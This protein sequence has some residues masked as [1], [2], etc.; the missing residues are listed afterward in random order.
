MLVL[1]REAKEMVRWGCI[2]RGIR[3]LDIGGEDSKGWVQAFRL[4]AL[5]RRREDNSTLVVDVRERESLG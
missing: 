2:R 4:S 1:C 5:R 3:V